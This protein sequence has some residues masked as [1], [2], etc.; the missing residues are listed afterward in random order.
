MNLRVVEDALRKLWIA[1]PANF[2]KMAKGVFQDNIV[3]SAVAVR[4]L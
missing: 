2:E 3:F 4:V 1:Q